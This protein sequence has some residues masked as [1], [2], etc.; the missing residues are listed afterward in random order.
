MLSGTVGW[1][2][3]AIIF[4]VFGYLFWRQ[5]K[6]KAEHVSTHWPPIPVEGFGHVS[7][8]K[9]YAPEGDD[10]DLRP[11]T[12]ETAELIAHK[13]KDVQKKVWM[14]CI[15]NYTIPVSVMDRMGE[16]NALGWCV[17]KTGITMFPSAMPEDHPFVVWHGPH[18]PIHLLF[19]DEMYY[20]YA[21]EVH[22]VFRYVIRGWTQ[23]YDTIDAQDLEDARQIQRW[24][25]KQWSSESGKNRFPGGD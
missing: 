7:V 18:G 4:I 11:L 25:N 15:G 17:D 20:W 12:I 6:N 23:I 2:A 21:H 1:I 9:H 5:R 10:L 14:M 3:V 22:N 8:P 19:Q 24:I 13:L 16:H